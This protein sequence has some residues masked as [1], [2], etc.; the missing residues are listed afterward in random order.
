MRFSNVLRFAAG[1]AIL[2][3]AAVAPVLAQS[4]PT[5]TPNDLVNVRSGAGLRFSVL[6]TTTATVTI[7]GRTDFDIDASCLALGLTGGWLRVDING[8]EGWVARCAGDVTGDLAGV[9]VLSGDTGMIV[10]TRGG[11]NALSGNLLGESEPSG[12]YITGF[13]TA[14]NANV[15]ETPSVKAPV[16]A[17]LSASTPI[18]TAVYVIGRNETGSW[19]RVQFVNAEGVTQTGW[20]A[21]FLLQLPRTWQQAVDVQ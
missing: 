13:V 14:S 16:I 6:T 7:T 10:P 1:I 21:R 4:A 12:K 18:A 15:R 11:S 9:P 3:V 2:V 5:F 8:I 17:R 20:M 19:V